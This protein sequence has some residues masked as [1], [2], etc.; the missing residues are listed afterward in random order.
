MPEKK[1]NAINNM[2]Q[3]H[4]L[5]SHKIYNKTFKN[6]NIHRIYPHKIFCDKQIK[7]RCITHDDKNIFYDDDNH[8]SRSGTKMLSEEILK[9]I[10]F[11]N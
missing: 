6:K 5:R 10:K 7:N 9:T 8:L 2:K 4:I 1:V 3:T 11:I